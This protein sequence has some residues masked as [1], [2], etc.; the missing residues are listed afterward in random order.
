MKQLNLSI[1][2][3]LFKSIIPLRRSVSVPKKNR[4]ENPSRFCVSGRARITICG[5]RDTNFKHP[6]INTTLCGRAVT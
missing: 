6:K 5:G 2:V 1:L 3:E 4:K